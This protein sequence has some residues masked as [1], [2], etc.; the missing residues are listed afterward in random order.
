M[1]NYRTGVWFPSNRIVINT[2]IEI[3]EFLVNTLFK[4]CLWTYRSVI[5]Y[6]LLFHKQRITN[7]DI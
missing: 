5:F 7:N 6:S 1:S 3:P 4:N 2:A